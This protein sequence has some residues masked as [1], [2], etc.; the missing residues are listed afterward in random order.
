MPPLLEIEG[1]SIPMSGGGGGSVDH[2]TG[3]ACGGGSMDEE[4]CD[5]CKGEGGGG[6]RLMDGAE[7]DTSGLGGG[8]RIRI[9]GGSINGA[10]GDACGDK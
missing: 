8:E 9:V 7:I 4:T 2:G 1:L 5:T 3:D 10:Y 6:V